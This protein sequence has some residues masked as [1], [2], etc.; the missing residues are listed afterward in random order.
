[1]GSEECDDHNLNDQDGCSSMGLVE[2]GY[3][4]TG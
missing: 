4:C 3:V 2:D 1:M